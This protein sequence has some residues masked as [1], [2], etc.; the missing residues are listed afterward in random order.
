MSLRIPTTD[1]RLPDGRKLHYRGPW[2]LVPGAHQWSTGDQLRVL[3]SVDETPHGRLMHVSLSYAHKNPK[4]T[5]I[6]A[7]RDLFIPDT[8]DAM[9]VLPCAEDYVNFQQ[10]TFHVWQTPAPWGIR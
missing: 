9:M 1:L 8:V 4:W 2:P 3:A 6:R 10:H 5:E 7:V